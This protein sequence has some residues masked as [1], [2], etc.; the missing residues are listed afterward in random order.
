VKGS[1]SNQR[2]T[3]SWTSPLEDQSYTIIIKLRGTDKADQPVE[4]PVLVSN[5]VKC[6]TC[7]RNNKSHIK[8]C[9]ECGTAVF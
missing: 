4:K 2:L 6:S 3:Q 8:Y 5:K 1:E 7:G 9:P